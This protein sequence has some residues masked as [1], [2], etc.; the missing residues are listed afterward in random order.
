VTH[1]TDAE[2]RRTYLGFIQDAITRMA[3]EANTLKAWLV[4]VVTA[5]YGYA[6]VAHSWVVGLVGL[7][8]SLA[9]GYQAAHYLQQERA[10]RDLYG[11]AVAGKAEHFHMDIDERVHRWRVEMKVVCSWSIAGFFGLI[12]TGGL[13]IVIAE[14]IRP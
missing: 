10:F 3:G 2:D 11:D 9:A 13:V 6:L 8:A 7:L 4:P 5:A 12:A 14:A 1:E